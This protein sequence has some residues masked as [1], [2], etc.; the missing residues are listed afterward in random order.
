[1]F[2]VT[3]DSNIVSILDHGIVPRL[4]E[5]SQECGE[6]IAAVYA[7]PTVQDCHTAL[8]QWLGDWFN[9][10]EEEEGQAITLVI[11]EFD[12]T[13]LAQLPQEVAFETR[14]AC[15]IPPTAFRSLHS[16]G[17]FERHAQIAFRQAASLAA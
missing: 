3:R 10:Q 1:M 13:G 17:A 6:S 7:F 16:E 8:S 5:R 15:T 4:G 11:V 9:D 12:P 2:H 14:F